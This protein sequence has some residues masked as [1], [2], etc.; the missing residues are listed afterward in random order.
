MKIVYLAATSELGPASRYRI[1][2]F[3]NYFEQEGIDIDVLPALSDAWL[4]A[5]RDSG[6][7]R[8]IGR[9][10]SGSAGLVRRFQQLLQV[11]DHDL[12][13]IE[14]ELFP[15]LP[16]FIENLLLRSKGPYGVEL[17]DAIYLA[18]GRTQKYARFVE[19]SA[20]VIAGN[21]NLA[22]WTR[23]HQ[24]NTHVIPTC[25][26]VDRYTPKQN[27]ELGSVAKLGWVG[28]PVNFQY[29]QPLSQEIQSL[30]ASMPCRL[31][32]VSGRRPS[33]VGQDAFVPWDSSSEADAIAQFDIGVMPLPTSS[34][35][36]GKCGLKILQYMAAG[37]PVVASAVGVNRTIIQDGVNGL[38]VERLDQWKPAIE[39][40]LGDQEL[41]KKIGRAGR[42]RVETDYSTKVWGPKLVA[43]Y[44]DLAAKH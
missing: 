20:F 14:R 26:P 15:K 31:Q 12:L 19:N 30:R 33:F 13:I 7:K 42:Q 6:T 22:Q 1:Y 5:E 37:I 4:L 25:V 36:E 17:D 23:K 41:R 39:R 28:L 18:P 44:Q 32:V 8:T 3:I 27:Y 29:L 2:Q 9:L 38:L 10:K 21:E 16:G 43:L 35:A 24:P 11:G 34:F 40:L